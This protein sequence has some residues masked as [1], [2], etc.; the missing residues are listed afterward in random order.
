[1]TTRAIESKTTRFARHFGPRASPALVCLALLLTVS[2]GCRHS[3]QNGK[4]A[5][6]KGAGT[7]SEV[8][9]TA[10]ITVIHPERRDIRMIV[11]QPG[12]IEAFESTP[13]YSRIAGYAQ[14]YRYNIGDRVKEGDVLIDMWIPD[15]V[16]SHEQKTASVHRAEV[17]IEVAQSALRAA[18]AKLSTTEARIVS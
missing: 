4:S 7:R 8:G 2:T 11:T 9:K 16:Q 18:E 14:K 15:L 10:G 12:T 1:M 5:D 17:Q 3:G 6:A 13:I